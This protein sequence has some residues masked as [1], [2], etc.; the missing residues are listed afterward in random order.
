[1]RTI[2]IWGAAGNMGTRA[3]NRLRENPE[4]EVL[5]VEPLAAGVARLEARGDR[6]VPP[7]EA[8]GAA[9]VI[10]LAIADKFIKAVAPDLVPRMKPGVMLLM[11]D[12]AAAYAGIIPERADI[13]V[14]V[15]HPTH[16]PVF[17]DETDPEARRDYFGAGKAR[18]SIVS[19]LVQGP[20]ADYDV[21]EAVA[22]TYF[23]P[24]LRSHRV[25]LEQMAILE[26]A[27]SETCSATFIVAMRE[28]M[29]AAIARGVPRD[30]AFDFLMGHINVQLAIVFEQIDWRMS[31]GAYH[32]IDRAMKRIFRPDWKGVFDPEEVK[33]SVRGICNV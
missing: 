21:G 1:M 29:E 22:R 4:Y 3:C 30:A 12:P 32:V 10:V 8:A 14:F 33:A 7:V 19:A 26:P 5:C 27:M 13:S 9:D 2:A 18:Q 6:P 28:A 15:T 16:P 31:E 17:N 20:E 24:I 25:T 23:S 11:L